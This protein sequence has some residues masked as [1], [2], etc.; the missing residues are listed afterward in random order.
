MRKICYHQMHLQPENARKCI[1]TQGSASD[2]TGRAQLDHHFTIG[3]EA[4]GGERR[5]R[6]VG[7]ERKRDG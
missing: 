1:C 6:W 2:P 5:G 4:M 3:G 7:K